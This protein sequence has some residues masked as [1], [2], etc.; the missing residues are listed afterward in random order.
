[1]PTRPLHRSPAGPVRRP[2]NPPPQHPRFASTRTVSTRRVSYGGV[3]VRVPATWRVVDL[4]KTPG[5]CVRLDV[6]TIYTGP[7]SAQQD[8]PGHLV[9]RADTIWLAPS[10][11][12]SA[13]PNGRVGAMKAHVAADATSHEQLAAVAGRKVVI[14]ATWGS[15]RTVLDGVLATVV[16]TSGAVPQPDLS[17]SGTSPSL[18]ATN[19]SAPSAASPGAR[20]VPT[21][22][23]AA[24]SC[25]RLH[26]AGY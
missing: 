8:C 14:Q 16:G 4:A 20:A 26:G 6:A 3:S 2:Q 19:A 5:S 23:P 25:A 10:P 18:T 17:R 15:T 24:G 9:G 12:P 7:A 11:A 13:R 21:V 1:M 22:T